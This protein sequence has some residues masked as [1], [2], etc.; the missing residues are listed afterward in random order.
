MVG[1]GGRRNSLDDISLGHV[2]GLQEGHK[3]FETWTEKNPLTR[4]NVTKEHET[5]AGDAPN[6]SEI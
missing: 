2:W 3:P 5:I 4:S 6:S 1:D